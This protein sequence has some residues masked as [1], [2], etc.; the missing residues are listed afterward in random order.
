MCIAQRIQ[1][2]SVF[3]PYYEDIIVRNTTAKS[4]VDY[5]ENPKNQKVK[6][7]FY[8]K[9]RTGIFKEVRSSNLSA[10]FSSHNSNTG[11]EAVSDRKGDKITRSRINGYYANHLKIDREKYIAGGV[12]L[13]VLNYSIKG[14]TAGPG[15]SAMAIDAGF[16]LSYY[17]LKT[18]INL[19][20]NQLPQP[21]LSPFDYDSMV[22]ERYAQALI[23]REYGNEKTNAYW[24]GH[25]YARVDV[26]SNNYQQYSIGN[27]LIYSQSVS[28]GISANSDGGFFTSLGYKYHTK[29]NHTIDL[30]IGYHMQT[31]LIVP[32]Y[33]VSSFQLGMIFS[34]KSDNPLQTRL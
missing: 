27:K 17:D 28:W 24:S 3:T 34:L 9:Q 10:H 32:R 11:I 26:Y 33:P 14:S 19:T 5:L 4:L 30:H 29:Q 18:T 7:S 12:Y 20:V 31:A 1:E 23:L 16:G 6:A 2:T 21:S 15:G 13:G 8:L 22:H 25:Y